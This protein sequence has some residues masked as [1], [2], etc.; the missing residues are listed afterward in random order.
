MVKIYD[1]VW[2]NR[3]YS[4][5]DHKDHK[6]LKVK[7][8]RTLTGDQANHRPPWPSL[9]SH[10][11]LLG[12]PMTPPSSLNQPWS[13]DSWNSNWS[14]KPLPGCNHSCPCFFEA[15]RLYV[16]GVLGV[17]GT[18]VSPCSTCSLCLEHFM[19][20]TANALRAFAWTY[21]KSAGHWAN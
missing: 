17:L 1:L 4:H 18:K 5:K 8:A 7:R 11:L 2:K 21:G 6:L 20:R 12:T 15:Q 9:P 19:L 13:W 3:T 14:K 10:L 16:L